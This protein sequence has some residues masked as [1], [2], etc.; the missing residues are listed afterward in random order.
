MRPIIIA[1]SLLA[2]DPANLGAEARR[3]GDSGADWLHLDIMDGHFVPNL[4]FGPAIVA[5]AKRHTSLPLDVHLMLSRPDR[6]VEAFAKAGAAAITVHVEAEH[7]V[8][9]TL[10]Q[11]RRLG[12]RR[13]L[14]LNPD[15]P[16]GKAAPFFRDIELLLAMTVHPGF[17]GQ[18]LI[19]D[20]LNKCREALRVRDSLGLDFDIQVDGG[21]GIDNAPDCARAGA[22]VLV[23]GT[24]LYA[25]GDMGERV[26]SMRAAA[27]SA[28]SSG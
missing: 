14:A 2:A 7:D 20:V 22:N 3:A 26:R 11:I 18:S 28:I 24:S 13:G 27:E 16:L 1:P 15:T 10:E 5:A 4:S 6:Y 17:G 21:V 25:P 12:C 23:A 8:A 9:S 19:A